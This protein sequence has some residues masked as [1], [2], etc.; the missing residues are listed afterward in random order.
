MQLQTGYNILIFGDSM[1]YFL[2]KT[3]RIF[4]SAVIFISSVR[5]CRNRT[6]FACANVV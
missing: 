4:L 2:P 1:P 5:R 6:W 3:I